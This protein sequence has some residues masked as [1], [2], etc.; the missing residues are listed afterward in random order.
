MK[1][2]SFQSQN[3]K[4]SSVIQK[5]V[6]FQAF[7]EGFRTNLKN[8]FHIEGDIDK[9]SINRGLPPKVLHEIMSYNPLSICI[10]QQFG[11]RGGSIQESLAIMSEA[12]YE[13]LALSLTLSINYALFLQ[14]VTKYGH[15]SV[16]A[17]IFKRFL[18]H[19]N[20]GG[21]MITEPG[22]GSDALNM[23]TSYTEEDGHYQI[24]GRKHWGG[25]TGMANFW[26]LTA[27][28]RGEEGLRRDID[29]FICDVDS[30]GQ[31][32]VVEEYFENLGL[33]QI[34]YGRN[35]IDVRIPELQRLIPKTSG[36]Q[37][38]L[39]T[40]HRSRV[41][42]PGMAMGFIKRML[43]EAIEH[44]RQRLVGNKPLSSYDQVQ[45]RMARLQAN[46]TVCSALLTMSSELGGLEKDLAPLGLE[47][48]I[49]KT[50]T[51]DLMQEASQSLLQLVGAK[52]YRLNHIAGRA[53]VDSRPFQIFE[54][55]NDILYVQ[56]C[57]TFVKLMSTAKE[58]NFYQF[59]KEFH[60][61]SC[62]AEYLTKELLNFNLEKQL[63]QRKQVELGQVISRIVAMN[64]VMK[65]SD[66]GFRSDLI[67]NA[68]NML[69]QEITMLI[70]TYA[71]PQSTLVVEDYEEN[72]FWLDFVKE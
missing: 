33:Y 45:Q 67:N 44:S 6:P 43:D 61:S 14:P 12:S 51:T 68:L 34:P 9:F 48:N 17:P 20:M 28:K 2:F 31:E 27:R 7:L 4:T 42:F 41:Q 35:Y 69:H 65:V 47:A 37:M 58:Y 62:A 10:P 21:L 11:G 36:I 1:S 54:G 13:S 49:M 59:L 60:L 46:Y 63:S 66:R 40:L 25:L 26:L 52:G 3:G 56:I 32:I 53:T 5:S 39:D 71:C 19:Q 30:K 70:S 16:K 72:S 18:H 23:Q 8:A 50:I 29:F 55:S 24:Q 15:E 57:E 22:H 64:Y 38:M